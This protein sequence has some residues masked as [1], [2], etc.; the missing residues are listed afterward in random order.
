MLKRKGK[1]S[2]DNTIDVDASMQG[3]LKFGD[4]VCLKINGFFE[5]EL[6][7]KGSLNIGKSA[8]VKA[9]INS[10]EVIIAG[11]MK[12]DINARKRVKLIP[13]AKVMGTIISP[14]LL[15]EEG[16]LFKGSCDMEIE[17]NFLEEIETDKGFLSTKYVAEYL[18]VDISMVRKWAREGE[19]PA[20]KRGSNWIF[21]RQKIEKWVAEGRIPIQEE[22]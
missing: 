12:G 10:Y 3:K 15:V 18:G 21:N 7:I 19:I 20:Q 13:P 17:D 8:K 14:S 16:A 11:A 9:K 22:K 5:G 1:V 6:D 4:P 2:E